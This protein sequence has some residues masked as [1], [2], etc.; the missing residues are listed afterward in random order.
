LRLWA[1]PEEYF[2]RD[3]VGQNVA[4]V[5]GL[6]DEAYYVN[7]SGGYTVM[8]VKKGALCI[9]LVWQGPN[10]DHQKIIDAEQTIAAQVLPEL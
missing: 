7:M 10:W 6:G 3:M 5:S 8:D 9:R 1:F 2:E 4:S